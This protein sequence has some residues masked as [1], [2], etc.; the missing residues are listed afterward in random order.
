MAHTFQSPPSNR[1]RSMSLRTVLT[2]GFIPMDCPSDVILIGAPDRS[3][4]KELDFEI[5]GAQI[6]GIGNGFSLDTTGADWFDITSPISPDS[7]RPQ[8]RPSEASWMEP[9]WRTPGRYFS[10]SSKRTSPN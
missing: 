7:L 8:R 4:T 5:A 6:T 1:K 9:C 3:G 2:I 10:G